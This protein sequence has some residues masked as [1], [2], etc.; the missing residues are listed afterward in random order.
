[1]VTHSELA[2]HSLLVGQASE[3]LPEVQATPASGFCSG[4]HSPDRHSA[5]KVHAAPTVCVGTRSHWPVEVLQANR[6]PQGHPSRQSGR[7]APTADAHT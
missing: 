6:L 2:G 7:H 5:F 1:M 3:Q 4:M